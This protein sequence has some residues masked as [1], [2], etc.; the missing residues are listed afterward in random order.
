MTSALVITAA[1]AEPAGG[2]NVVEAVNNGSAALPDTTANP[3]TLDR[4]FENSQT[5]GTSEKFEARAVILSRLVDA[6][7]L[8]RA[9]TGVLQLSVLAGGVPWPIRRRT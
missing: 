7:R 1:E 6:P 5:P 8:R 4:G 3:V 9:R 2:A